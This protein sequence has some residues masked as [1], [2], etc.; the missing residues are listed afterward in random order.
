MAGRNKDGS[1]PSAAESSVVD[2]RT[3]K[4][5]PSRKGI[6]ATPRQKEILDKGRATKVRQGKERQ[7]ARESGEDDRSRWEMYLSGDLTI[8]QWDDQELARMQTRSFH[9]DFQGRP[10]TLKPNMIREIKAELLRRGERDFSKYGIA[11]IKVVA[12]IMNDPMERAADRLRAANI[13]LERCYGKVP[14]TV[15]LAVV[16]A[17]QE[18]IDKVMSVWSEEDSEE[19]G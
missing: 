15:K 7:A 10:P 12:R 9:G 13:F 11:A 16:E 6:P 14:E 4:M 3:R 17:W 5:P 2:I 8:D 19:T 18:D 1:R